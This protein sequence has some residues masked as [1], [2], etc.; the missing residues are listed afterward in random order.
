MTG[1]AVFRAALLDPAAA[2]PPGLTDPRG[3]PAGKRFDVHRNNV[4]ASLARALE[5]GFPATR[6]YLGERPFRALAVMHARAHPPRTPVLSGY[7]ATLP[8]FLAGL[9]ALAGQPFLPDLARLELA[10]RQGYHAADADPIDPAALQALP[11]ERLLAA[12]LGLAPALRLVRS[13]H[14]VAGLWHHARGAGAPPAPGPEAALVTRP[15]F[16]PVV[17]ALDPASGAAL[18]ALLQGATVEAAIDAGGAG[19]DPAALLTALVTGQAI[20]AIQEARP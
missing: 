15:G 12:R 7:G 17:T 9:P 6:H 8:D 1:Q 4:V 2:V 10:I 14:P 5:D 16:D 19:F 20:T 11:P 13:A 18:A 3:R